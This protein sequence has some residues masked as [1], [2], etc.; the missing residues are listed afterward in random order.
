MTVFYNWKE[1]HYHN[2]PNRLST[3]YINSFPDSEHLCAKS[4]ARLLGS[5]CL[6]IDYNDSYDEDI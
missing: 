2:E 3:K 5:F 6:I 4:I 1:H